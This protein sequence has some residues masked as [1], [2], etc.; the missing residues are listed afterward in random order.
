MSRVTAGA[1]RLGG[2]AS[3]HSLLR[4]SRGGRPLRS[5]RRPVAQRR[6]RLPPPLP[7]A[8]T[9][10]APRRRGVRT[11]HAGAVA[12]VCVRQPRAIW[13]PMAAVAVDRPPSVKCRALPPR[14]SRGLPTSPS[15]PTASAGGSPSAR[16]R[17]PDPAGAGQ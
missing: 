2:N 1:P 5:R 3:F 6:R 10:I 9:A 12:P 8:R 16:G 13:R 15:R 7:P 14:Q 4:S 17:R 11:G